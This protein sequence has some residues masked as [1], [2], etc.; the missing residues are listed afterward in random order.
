MSVSSS[1]SSPGV[2]LLV[3]SAAAL[4]TPRGGSDSQILGGGSHV[5][6]ATTDRPVPEETVRVAEAAFPK[7]SIYVQ[8]RDEL[9]VV[10][11]DGDFSELFA[12]RGRPAHAP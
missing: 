2:I 6:A 12:V 4:H 11:H 1:R 10:Y 7:G 3:Y 9:G 5:D 8:M